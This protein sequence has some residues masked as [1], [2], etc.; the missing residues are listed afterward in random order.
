MGEAAPF[1]L[2]E[3]QVEPVRNRLIGP[4]G[5]R[6]VEPRVM[7]LLVLFAASPGEVL[8]RAEIGATVWGGVH[9]NDDALGRT[10]WKLRQA[11]G[12]DARTP[13]FI[14]TV[15]KRGYRLIATPEVMPAQAPVFA[16]PP[17]QRGRRRLLAG[18]AVIGLAL[19]AASMFMLRPEVDAPDADPGPDPE[20]ESAPENPDAVTLRRADAFYHQF[21][22]TDNEAALRLYEAVLEGDPDNGA[23]LAGLSNALTQQV[24]RWR[25][26]AGTPIERTSLGEAL[27]SGYL[28][29]EEA[30]RVLTRARRLAEA[31][32]RENPAHA[33]AYRSLGL[34]LAA[35]GEFSAAEDAYARALVIDPDAWGALINLSE[36]ASFRGDETAALSYLEQA[37]EVMART[38]DARPLEI[39]PWHSEVGLSVAARHDERGSLGEAELWYR[40]V[41]SSDPLN[42]AAVRGLAGVLSR[43]GDAGAADALCAD[44]ERR[45][46]QACEP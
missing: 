34:V 27:A 5:E 10:V 32:I 39:R 22:R 26:E 11:L 8:S 33:R 9:V 14:E 42:Q 23:A 45:T 6:E 46:G 28:D 36:M 43:A 18:G 15:P 21:T 40:R 31:A 2:L 20:A 13:R 19:I 30:Q 17:R 7:D 38:Y 41:L 3:W 1:Q 35:Q 4:D 25:G 24:I 12:D 44:F 37:Y 29:T 16:A